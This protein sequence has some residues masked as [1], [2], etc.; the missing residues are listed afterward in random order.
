MSESA[1]RAERFESAAASPFFTWEVSGK[2]VAV[3][4]PHSIVDRLEKEAVESFRS[5]SSRG[6]EIGGLLL[7]RIAPGQPAVV[8]VEGYEA[9]PCDYSRGPLYRLS[10][11]DT[12]RMAK[13]IEQKS[14][15]GVAAVGFF[16]SQTRKGLGLDADDL[17]LFRTRFQNPGQIALLIRP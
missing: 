14:A 3:Q 17:E 15:G 10:E 9:V 8:S 1:A 13:A 4:I 12:A 6:S 2:P 11:A 7:G 5:L 16:R